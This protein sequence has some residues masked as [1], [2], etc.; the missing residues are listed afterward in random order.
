MPNYKD[1]D[2]DSISILSHITPSQIR[3]LSDEEIESLHMKL[4]PCHHNEIINL[5]NDLTNLQ[6]QIRSNCINYGDDISQLFEDLDKLDS[7][8]EYERSKREKLTE[9]YTDCIHRLV[10]H[11]IFIFI[12]LFLF[13]FQW[14]IIF[15]MF[16]KMD[17]LSEQLNVLKTEETEIIDYYN[18]QNGIGSASQDDNDN[19]LRIGP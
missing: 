8:I 10:A 6:S 5:R 18:F 17:N 1:G 16:H 15:F 11:R 3:N 9:K 19:R 4:M 12:F 2:I 13:L 14:V 7:S